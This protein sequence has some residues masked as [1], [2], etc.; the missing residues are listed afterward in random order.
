VVLDAHEEGVVAQLDDLDEVA[1]GVR[2]ADHEADRLE[3]VAAR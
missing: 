2:A 1:L 3:A